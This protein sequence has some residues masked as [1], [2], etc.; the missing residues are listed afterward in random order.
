MQA[1]AGQAARCVHT[2]RPKTVTRNPTSQGM[3]YNM[4]EHILVVANILRYLILH[5]TLPN[6]EFT[7]LVQ[8]LR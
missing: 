6:F 1:Q 2:A 7:S 4:V 5:L 8:V 3:Q